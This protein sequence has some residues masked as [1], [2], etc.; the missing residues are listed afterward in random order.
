MSLSYKEIQLGGGVIKPVHYHIGEWYAINHFI[1]Q[2]MV[3]DVAT[4]VLDLGCG[5]GYGVGMFNKLGYKR[6]LG[7]D[8]N[9][10]KIEIGQELGYNV[11]C[12]DFMKLQRTNFD[13]IWSSHS[14]EHMENPNL[15]IEKLIEISRDTAN[16][17][18]ILP[19]PDL[20]PAPAHCS[21]KE[22]GLSVDDNAITLV[23][24][25]ESKGLRLLSRKFD[26]FREPEVWL[27]FDKR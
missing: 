25:F 19:Y 6:V 7:V 10:K 12:E 24:W 8:I 26:K 23:R 14:F 13:V 18:F 1:S 5:I 3:T 27:K 16:F 4:K 11:I 20:D 9:D 21:S 2:S 15:A 22:I 17:Y